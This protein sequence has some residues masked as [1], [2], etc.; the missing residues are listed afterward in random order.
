MSFRNLLTANTYTH[1]YKTGK[2]NTYLVTKA[3]LNKF[4]LNTTKKAR[5]HSYTIA[6]YIARVQQIFQ[7]NEIQIPE[8]LYVC[9]WIYIAYLQR[10]WMANI[11]WQIMW[12]V[13]GRWRKEK[14]KTRKVFFYVLLW[15][16]VAW[17]WLF[18]MTSLECKF[19][20]KSYYHDKDKLLRWFKNI[21]FLTL[22][23]S[24]SFNRIKYKKLTYW[25][26]ILRRLPVRIAD[27]YNTCRTLWIC[28]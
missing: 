9:V 5:T 24:A 6:W 12:W 10:S 26:N 22:R 15:D 11:L 1:P 16:Y 28:I 20:L 4:I 8:R 23:S 2:G 27:V 13:C 3:E 25:R 17:K 19:N 21:K 18:F 7:L 14:K